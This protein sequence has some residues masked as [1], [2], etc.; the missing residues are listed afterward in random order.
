MTNNN[1]KE[2]SGTPGY[3]SPEVMKGQNHSFVVDFFALGVIGY[4]FMLGKRPYVGKSRKEIKEQMI[5]K[6]A[7]IKCCDIPNGW[8]EEAADFFNKLLQRKPELRLGYKGYKE[9]K[10]HLWLKFFPWDQLYEKKLTAPF[11]PDK[12]DNFDKKY[13]KM[14]DNITEET[15][16][17]YDKYKKSQEYY[18]IFEN[19]TYYGI[20]PSNKNNSNK[21]NNKNNVCRNQNKYDLSN[22]IKL[23]NRSYSFIKQN[24]KNNLSINLDKSNKNYMKTKRSYSRITYQSSS[25]KFFYMGESEKKNVLINK[26]KNASLY[27]N[28]SNF[29]NFK[30]NSANCSKSQQ[31]SKDTLNYSNSY[32]HIVPLSDNFN[33]SPISRFSRTPVT[34][35]NFHEIKKINDLK[36]SYSLSHTFDKS[37]MLKNKNKLNSKSAN[38]LM[39]YQLDINNRTYN[40]Q[41]RSYAQRV[42]EKQAYNFNFNHLN[43]CNKQ[44]ENSYI[45]KEEVSQSTNNNYNNNSNI[46]SSNILKQIRNYKSKITAKNKNKQICL[47]KKNNNNNRKNIC[48]ELELNEQNYQFKNK[49]SKNSEQNKKIEKNKIDKNIVKLYGMGSNININVVIKGD[50]NTTNIINQNNII[51]KKNKKMIRSNSMGILFKNYKIND[52]KNK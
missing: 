50:N 5:L 3:M 44:R 19:F 1:A 36:K 34:N 35:K 30:K 51:K 13:C 10:E 8:S 33:K 4:E 16:L 26:M 14:T 39:N 41:K 32:R 49:I 18:R 37:M 29:Q 9:I 28:N 11:I 21:N 42:R 45:S 38:K 6:Q 43:I 20:I 15:K 31:T 46:S 25:S 24:S 23:G 40:N 52:N 7:Q 17:K 27:K 22:K 12:K 2:T 47:N 48:F